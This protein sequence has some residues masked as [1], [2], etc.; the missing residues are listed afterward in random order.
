MVKTAFEISPDNLSV[1]RIA[2]N[3]GLIKK[4]KLKSSVWVSIIDDGVKLIAAKG[5]SIPATFTTI[6]GTSHDNQTKTVADIVFG[7]YNNASA[8][9]KLVSMTLEGLP[10][11]PAGKAEVKF[12]F[13]IDIDGVIRIE[14]MSLDTGIKEIVEKKAKRII[15]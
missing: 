1:Q 6:M 10:Q 14:K 13:S 2:N 5:S 8:N 15:E 9:E 12:T 3:L 7:E 4:Y 11:K